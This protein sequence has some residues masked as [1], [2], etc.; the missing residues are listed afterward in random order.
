MQLEFAN[1]TLDVIET[2][3]TAD[4]ALPVE[5]LRSVRHR[6]TL[7]RAAP[8]LFTLTNWRSFGLLQVQSSG[9]VSSVLINDNWRLAV[10]FECEASP[11]RATVIGINTN[12]TNRGTP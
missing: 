10:R 7:I 1:G 12:Q 9:G 2:G 8:D 6:L 5:V 11:N 4:A 3:R